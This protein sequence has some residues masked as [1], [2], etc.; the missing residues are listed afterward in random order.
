VK[1]S[2]I[3]P[4]YNEEATIGNVIG[5]LN[6]ISTISEVIVVSDGSTDNT[7]NIAKNMKAK[8]LEYSE[9][10]GKGGAIKAALEVCEGDIILFLDADLIGLKEEHVYK[11]LTPV[12]N[13]EADMTVGVFTNGRLSTNFSHKVSPQL[14]G[15]R[16]VKK[17]VLDTMKNVDLTGYGIEVA[18]NIHAKEMKIRVEEIELDGMTHVMKEEKFGVVRGI[19]HRMKMYWQIIKGIRLAKR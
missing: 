19:L 15:Q 12:I 11:L 3:I 7:P 14:S 4:A 6:N 18:L 16:A 13:D 1:V 17:F 10:R 2:S 8:V 9:N 5:I